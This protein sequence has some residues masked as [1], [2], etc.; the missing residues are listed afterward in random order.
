MEDCVPGVVA[1]DQTGFVKG[2]QLASNIRRLLNVVMN[3][4]R[5]RVP[6]VVVSMDAEKAFDR[7]EWR[8]LFEVLGRFG[9]GPRFV[10]WVR[11]LYVAPRARVRTND[12]SS[13]SFELH[14]G[15]RQGCPLSPLLFALAIEPLAMA[16][17]GST[18]WQG[19]MRGQREHRVSLYAD[20]L[21][22]VSDP[23]ESMAKIMD[24]LGRFG[25]FSGY[26][27]NV[28]KSKVFP[29]NELAQRANLGGMTFKVARERFRYLGI[30]V[31][32]EWTGLHKWNL[33]KL[34]E[35]A[36]EDFK[37]WD[38]L[39]LTLARQGSSGEDEYSAEVPVHL[40]DAPDLYTKGLFSESGHNHFRFRMGGEGAEG[41]EDPTTEAKAA[42]GVGVAKLAPLLLGSKCG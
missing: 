31:M 6:E 27:L 8:Y 23:L 28:G 38:T 37:R 24:L 32:R 35:E 34:V 30:Q 22:Y 41:G 13:R 1:E 25:A 36:R 4:S 16:L 15:T 39:H 14:R 11:L 20:D 9:F 3:P 10:A 5:A 12:M 7:V 26:K 18:E 40:P 29:V 19:I 21:L 2:R 17:R 33:A 42:G